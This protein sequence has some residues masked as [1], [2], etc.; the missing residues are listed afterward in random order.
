MIDPLKRRQLMGM[1]LFALIALVLLLV[2][3]IRELMRSGTLR[4]LMRGLRR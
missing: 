1:V 3:W 4:A 2:L